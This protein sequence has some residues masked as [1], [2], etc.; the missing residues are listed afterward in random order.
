[1]QS[2][3]QRDFC[4]TTDDQPGREC[5][6]S[7]SASHEQSR[8]PKLFLGY[9]EVQGGEPI[10]RPFVTSPQCLDAACAAID[11]KGG[12]NTSK[13][14]EQRKCG[15]AHVRWDI[16]VGVQGVANR[17]SRFGL[18]SAREIFLLKFILGDSGLL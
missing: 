8:L 17:N 10:Y 11:S 14:N 16:G 6:G 4:K 13:G 5:S 3:R 15:A 7:I 2:S 18:N 9:A 1:V 12:E